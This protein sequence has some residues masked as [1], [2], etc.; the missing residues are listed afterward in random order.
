[1]KLDLFLVGDAVHR[2]PYAVPATLTDYAT[3]AEAA[4][5]DAVWLAEHHFIRYGACAS[6]PLLAAHILARTTRLAVGSAACVLSN[7]N[8]VALAEE[9]VMLDGLSDGRFKLGVARGGPWVDLEVFGS[10]MD[11]F[12]RG[13]TEALDVL[14]QWLSGAE[15]VGSQGEF[16]RFR[17]VT[18][19]ARPPQP[20]P[21][22]VAATSAGTV[23]EAARRGIP[24]L[25]GVHA[26]DADKA[27]LT[28]RWAR[29]A[30]AA[31]HD[32]DRAEHAAVYLAYAA[33][34]QSRGRDE[35]R[36]PL[37]HWL[38]EGVGDYLR[39]DG[40]RGSRDQ[41]GYV[42]KLIDMHLIGSAADNRERLAASMTATGVR[43]ALLLVE[44]RAEAEAVRDN[45]TNLAADLA[46]L[47]D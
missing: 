3:T 40:G 39:L 8:P 41:Q 1:M 7:R 19:T 14:R 34:S 28:R 11:R 26:T 32:P 43:R 47:R 29:T 2:D 31:G 33:D 16:H 30:A 45:I 38:S 23:D 12:E 13:F 9:A 10:G 46:P 42:D 17:P 25:L 22:W 27:E 24:L 35:L 15:T 37:T 36:K 6:V 44:G 20:P 21:L 5:F 18:V 4:G